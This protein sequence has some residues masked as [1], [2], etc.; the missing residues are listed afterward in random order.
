MLSYQHAYHAGNPADVHK[1]L[2]LV[3]LLRRLQHKAKPF[4]FIDTHAGRGL[5]DLE[6]AQARKTREA[7]TGVLRLALTDD[8]PGPVR[9]YLSLLAARN[10]QGSIRFYPG[11]AAIAHAMLRDV[12]RAILFELH[13]QE[14]AAL[15]QF[16][17]SDPRFG[18]H[19]RDC[20]EALPALVPPPIRRGLVL[21][22]PSYEM[23]AEYG[24]IVGLL[25]RALRR[26]A[27]GIYLLWYPLLPD[28]RDRLLLRQ[29]DGLAAPKTLV[30]EYT[31]STRSDGMRGSGLVIVNSPWQ[32]DEELDTA[33]QYIIDVLGSGSHSVTWQRD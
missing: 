8:A 31:F 11:S 27:N 1:H 9:D 25:G 29:I 2:A 30:S 14:A 17:A 28:A 24:D 22:D 3:M 10:R 7:E 13:P 16:I 12:D 23:K 32:F 5:Y 26:W 20:Y 6:S 19:V 21:I 33:M 15:R 18:L 4:T